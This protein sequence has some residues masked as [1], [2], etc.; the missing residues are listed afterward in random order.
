MSIS[1]Q[2]S[3]SLTNNVI[4]LKIARLISSNINANEI[5]FDQCVTDLTGFHVSFIHGDLNPFTHD[6]WFNTSSMP[7]TIGPICLQECFEMTNLLKST[8]KKPSKQAANIVKLEKE[9]EN[10]TKGENQSIVTSPITSTTSPST[11]TITATTIITVSTTASTT[12]SATSSTS[13]TTTTST[14]TSSTTTTSTT[15]T[16]I[17]STTP[18]PNVCPNQ[19]SIIFNN[20]S[21]RWRFSSGYNKIGDRITFSFNFMSHTNKTVFIYIYA[22]NRVSFK[23]LKYFGNI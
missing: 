21:I 22:P 6:I 11:S 10:I 3:L 14:S 23:I 15:S 17:R 4:D 8:T 19:N 1:S 7:K 13:S 18:D 20:S 16:T 9:S 5:H 12:A 2:S